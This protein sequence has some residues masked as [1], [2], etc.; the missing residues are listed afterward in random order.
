MLARINQAKKQKVNITNY[1]LAIAKLKNLLDRI[2][3]QKKI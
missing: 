3:F 2:Y 1:G